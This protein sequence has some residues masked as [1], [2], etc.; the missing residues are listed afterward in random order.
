MYSAGHPPLPPFEVVTFKESQPA[1]WK[2]P[3]DLPYFT[4]LATKNA[5]AC[6]KLFHYRSEDKE[7]HQAREFAVG[8]IVSFQTSMKLIAD[9]ALHP[10]SNGLMDFAHFD[11]YACHH[12]L[13]VPSDRQRRGYS[14]APGRPPL[15]AWT[16]VLP[17][18]VMEH[19]AQMPQERS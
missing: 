2:H 8:V 15:K 17:R 6:S 16:A 19:A 10:G 7:L 1:H 14:S 3:S 12:D 13:R 9:Q 4:D 18:I 11:C 5:Q